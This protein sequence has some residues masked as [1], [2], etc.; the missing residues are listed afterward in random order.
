MKNDKLKPKF[1]CKV[2]IVYDC[3]KVKGHWSKK[4]INNNLYLNNCVNLLHLLNVYLFYYNFKKKLFPILEICFLLVSHLLGF[5][6]WKESVHQK[7][8]GKV[9]IRKKNIV[10]VKKLKVNISIIYNSDINN[11]L[12]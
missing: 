3:L 5:F 4:F 9:N 12:W 7:V 8:I 10:L 1:V 6:V 2:N 11:N